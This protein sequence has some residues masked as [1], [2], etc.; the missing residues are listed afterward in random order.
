MS[1]EPVH[2]LAL[3]LAYAIGGVPTAFL[4]GQG[5]HGIDLRKVGSKNLGATNTFRVLGWKSGVVVLLID[6]FKGW[7]T[8]FLSAFL[9]PP[10]IGSTVS[11]QL[12]VGAAAVLGHIFSIYMRFKGG[13]GVATILGV[14]LAIHPWAALICLGVF[15]MLFLPT[16]YVSLGSIGAAFA[17]PI[18]VIL[19]FKAND[20]AMI[21]FSWIFSLLIIFT[22]RKN[23]AR[24]IGNRENKI[25]FTSLG[26]KDEEHEGAH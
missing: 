10:L 26:D 7:G 14:V 23:I 6:I 8:V 19:I 18:L 20:P 17:F 5:Y 3:S 11:L 9:F 15:F 16:R 24:L 2:I 12:A 21:H 1:P 25:R 22:H 13:K 4:V